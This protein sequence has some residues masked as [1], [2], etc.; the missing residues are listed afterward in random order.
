MK[1]VHIILSSRGISPNILTEML[2]DKLN[3][4]SISIND[5]FREVIKSKTKFTNEVKLYLDKG[6]LIPN[7]L[8]NKII[9]NRISTIKSDI[10]II[11]YPRTKEQYLSLKESLNSN[12]FLIEQ[13]WF[14]KLNDI[15]QLIN[16]KL[17]NES[18]NPYTIKFGLNKDVFLKNYKDSI[19]EFEELKKVINDESLI[20]VI[21]FDYPIEK[22]KSEIEKSIIRYIANRAFS[23][24]LKV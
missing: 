22:H 18:D 19:N 11:R 17:E 23:D 12:K 10:Q 21:D 20:S 14:L 5:L 1:K 6:E 4:T 15:Q 2:S 24:K 9:K 7:E 8:T 16:Y 13:I 3:L